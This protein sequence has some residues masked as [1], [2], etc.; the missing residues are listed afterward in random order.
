MIAEIPIK[1]IILVMVAVLSI[2]VK[3]NEYYYYG[4]KE[5]HR[6]K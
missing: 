1:D 2:N 3:M 4:R 5:K 6:Q